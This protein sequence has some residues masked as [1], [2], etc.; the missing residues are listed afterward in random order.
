MSESKIGVF[1]I[2][3]NGCVATAVTSGVFAIRRE[4]VKPYGLVTELDEFKMLPL[5]GLGQLH[6]FGWDLRPQP[7]VDWALKHG[8]ASER[9]LKAIMPDLTEVKVLQ[10]PCGDASLNLDGAATM[11]VSSHREC[12]QTLMAQMESVRRQYHLDRL[13]VVNLASTEA[14][15]RRT[16][17]HESLAAFECALHNSDDAITPGMLYAYASIMAGVPYV[18]FTPGFTADVPALIEL[19][20]SRGVPI[21]GKDGK[22]GQTLYKTV[23]APMFRM[24]NLRVRGWYSMNILGNDDGLALQQPGRGEAKQAT[25][26]ESLEHIL[27]YN[28]VDH[29]VH[30]H[31]Y[32]ERGDAKEAWDVVDF[33]GWLETPMSIRVDWQGVDSALAAPLVIDL[34]R[35]ILLAQDRN[36][37]GPAIHLAA[38]FKKPMGTT[39]HSF[40]EQLR[41]LHDYCSKAGN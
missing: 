9:I 20:L 22:T 35:M 33:L 13:A 27:G 8:T 21:A 25:K 16:E 18:N 4:L 30:I 28:D 2:G 24:R 41:T 39:E 15:V 38:F 34:V 1:L 17:A 36:E 19:A 37:G 11:R 7:H 23:L 40:F 26:R 14:I 29:Q 31:Y 32:R 5:A 12:I 6:F 10:A 3:V